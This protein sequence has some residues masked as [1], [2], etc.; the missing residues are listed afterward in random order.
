MSEEQP[1][2]GPKGRF[3]IFTLELPKL[4][5]ALLRVF[6]SLWLLEQERKRLHQPTHKPRR[7]HW[8]GG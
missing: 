6:G 3:S 7:G 8:K 4:N 1:G 2:E 5:L